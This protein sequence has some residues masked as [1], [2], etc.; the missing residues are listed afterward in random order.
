MFLIINK[1]YIIDEIKIS[2][3]LEALVSKNTQLLTESVIH[4]VVEIQDNIKEGNTI[5]LSDEAKLEYSN[6][7]DKLMLF[8]DSLNEGYVRALGQD[9]VSNLSGAGTEMKGW[10][11]G[12]KQK[13]AHIDKNSQE[14]IMWL[15]N[16]KE[17]KLDNSSKIKNFFKTSNI[18]WRFYLLIDNS[19]FNKI[20]S[21]I[22]SNNKSDLE[23]IF[24]INMNK[25]SSALLKLE[26]AK[27]IDDL[28]KLVTLYKE[29]CKQVADELLKRK[30]PIKGFS[31]QAMLVGLTDLNST[32]KRIVALSK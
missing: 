16:N 24:D 6:F 1:E 26:E 19:T 8:D 10:F 4:D 22:K 23:G 32:V 28:I 31:F 11:E 3:L 29:R 12:I 30:E 13:I 18:Q 7:I 17:V 15:K 2:N 9:I 27:S 14:L 25:R 5:V 21:D 20:L